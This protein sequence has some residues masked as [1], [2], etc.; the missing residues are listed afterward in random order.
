MTHHFLRLHEQLF[1]LAHKDPASA[2]IIESI[3]TTTF[4]LGGELALTGGLWYSYSKG[5]KRD[6][7]RKS[8]SKLVLEQE[9]RARSLPRRHH[10]QHLRQRY[11]SQAG[12]DA[13]AVAAHLDHLRRRSSHM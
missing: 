8:C 2:E 3:H 9:G 4:S 1:P 10:Q 11:R 7:R 12:R 6:I 13:L 5:G